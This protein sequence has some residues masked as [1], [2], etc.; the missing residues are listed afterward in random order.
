MKR[1]NSG[2]ARRV[3]IVHPN[4]DRSITQARLD[5]ELEDDSDFLSIAVQLMTLANEGGAIRPGWARRF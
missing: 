4:I 5:L 2:Y 3:F 1:N